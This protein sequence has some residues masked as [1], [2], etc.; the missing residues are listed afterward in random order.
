MAVRIGFDEDTDQLFQESLESIKKE[1][2]DFKQ[3]DMSLDDI[4]VSEARLKFIKDGYDQG[5]VV[6]NYGDDYHLSEEQRMKNNAYYDAFKPLRR[7]KKKYRKI[8]EWV[9]VMREYMNA[10]KT[11]AENNSRYS[12]EKFMEKYADGKIKIYGIT[13]PKYV[14]KDKKDINW[15][16]VWTEF[17]GTDKDPKELI[18]PTDIMDD[19]LEEMRN[20]L[21]T[22]EE[23][24]RITAPISDEEKY[25]ITHLVFDEDVDDPDGVNVVIPV[26]KKL[27]KEFIKEFPEI[28]GLIKSSK[29]A[30]A[31]NRG[32]NEFIHDMALSDIEFLDRYD[33]KH[34][35]RNKRGESPKFNG[36]LSGDEVN[37]Y[38]YEMNEYIESHVQV[39]YEGRMR[40]IEEINEI[41]TKEFLDS[42]GYNVR[43]CFDN[44]KEEDRI[45]KI[46]KRDKKTEDRLRRRLSD[47]SNRNKSLRKGYSSDQSNNKKSKKKKKNKSLEDD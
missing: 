31:A 10:I 39:N 15:E 45:K 36:N 6:N 4:F 16:Y 40:T 14:G 41:K 11:I 43:N 9:N 32:I 28:S 25:R 29:R 35:F 47:I 46:I 37:K 2:D 7:S 21:F 19:S 1:Q 20:R 12:T 38:L 5:V 8:D 27:S 23:Y 26:N 13:F 44:K 42:M 17:I 3:S 33:K 18:K 22:K 24:A 34:N 30:E